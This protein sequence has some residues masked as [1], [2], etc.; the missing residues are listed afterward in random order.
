MKQLL[1]ADQTESSQTINPI[2]EFGVI[3]S[4]TID[5]TNTVVLQAKVD[6]DWET[7]FTFTASE[8]SGRFPGGF[9]YRMTA[10]TAGPKAVA[11]YINPS[12]DRV[13][14]DRL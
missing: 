9:E 5:S 4:G 13:R 2:R 3:V 14:N 12:I 1:A 11:E 8:K 7:V 6:D 10:T